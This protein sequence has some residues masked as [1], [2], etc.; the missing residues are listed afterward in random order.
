[1]ISKEAAIILVEKY[2]AIQ[3]S[4]PDIYVFKTPIYTGFLKK[5]KLFFL[6]NFWSKIKKNIDIDYPERYV[7]P[8]KFIESRAIE[9]IV[10]ENIQDLGICWSIPY[11]T[12]QYYETGKDRYGA[13]GGGP[14]FVD[15]EDALMYQTGSAPIDWLDSFKEFKQGNKDRNI[16]PNWQPI[17]AK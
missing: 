14:I 8:D 11:C 12:K 7:R 4:R 13:I 10:F 9:I 6:A 15:K 5:V 2:L 1:M 16:F 17:K 3:N